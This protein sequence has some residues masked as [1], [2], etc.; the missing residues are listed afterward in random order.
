MSSLQRIGSYQL[1]GTALISMLC[2]HPVPAQESVPA[3]QRELRFAAR[4]F[5]EWEVIL[6]SDLDDETR[7]KAV[8]AMSMFARHGKTVPAAAS[9]RHAMEKD[10]SEAVRAEAGVALLSRHN[11]FGESALL[12]VLDRLPHE[13]SKAVTDH[14]FKALPQH[15]KAFPLVLTEGLIGLLGA[16]SSVIR[17]AACRSLATTVRVYDAK[18]P[19]GTAFE[20]KDW[21]V[22]ASKLPDKSGPALMKA[23]SDP[24]AEVRVE[25]V[26]A[27]CALIPYVHEPLEGQGNP[28]LTAQLADVLIQCLN[29]ENQF[30]RQMVLADV[31]PQLGIRKQFLVAAVI[32]LLEQEAAS[33]RDPAKSPNPGNMAIGKAAILTLGTMGEDAKPAL[34]LLNR[35]ANRNDSPY[36]REAHQ[37]ILA[38]ESGEHAILV[39]IFKQR[40]L[41]RPR[42]DEVRPTQSP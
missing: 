34:R 12:Q 20:R 2:V 24:S 29:D 28:K 10:A 17:A 41:F 8:A 23:C 13:P 18:D 6:Q 14:L 32:S 40:I 37:A 4:T 5:E 22:V 42:P 15:A 33:F 16:E 1:I 39:E 38:L 9:L 27:V 19:A 30:V 31:P 36:Y 21:F 7:V 35:L 3:S 26:S 11:E 25:A